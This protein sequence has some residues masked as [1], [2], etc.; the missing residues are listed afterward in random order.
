M[1]FPRDVLQAHSHRQLIFKD[2]NAV[3][4]MGDCVEVISLGSLNLFLQLYLYSSKLKHIHSLKL[5]VYV[6]ADG[7]IAFRSSIFGGG[8]REPQGHEQVIHSSEF[9]KFMEQYPDTK[10]VAFLDRGFTRTTEKGNESVYLLFPT[11]GEKS[12]TLS[13]GH[14][15]WRQVCFHIVTHT[16]Y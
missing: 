4:L 14:A 15:A 7:L 12:D 16:F 9:V 1:P 6:T 2:P 13:P 5:F 3:A 8:S 10:I 11:S